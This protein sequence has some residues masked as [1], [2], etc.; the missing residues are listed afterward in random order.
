MFSTFILS[1]N[2]AQDQAAA[3][4]K[5]GQPQKRVEKPNID[6]APKPIERS[7]ALARRA[8]RA[9]IE[10]RDAVSLLADDVAAVHKLANIAGLGILHHPPGLEKRLLADI[11]QRAA[12]LGKHS[13]WNAF[14]WPQWSLLARNAPPPSS[15][16]ESAAMT[17]HPASF[18]ALT[19][20]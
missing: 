17:T 8:F 19:A 15:P 10:K 13:F 2:P 11:F 3:S 12:F 7:R 5:S 4:G 16:T 1:G 18:D 9:L 14:I 20:R 6:A